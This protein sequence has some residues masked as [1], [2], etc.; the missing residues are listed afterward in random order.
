MQLNQI[1]FNN[2]LGMYFSERNSFKKPHQNQMN[3]KCSILKK[4][5]KKQFLKP[6][7]SCLEMGKI[8][9]QLEQMFLQGEHYV[10][11]KTTKTDP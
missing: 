11:K 2:L 4:K 7:G 9:I 8:A 6:W 1:L 10:Y 3:N 5:K